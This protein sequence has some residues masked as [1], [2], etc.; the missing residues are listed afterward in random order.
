MIILQGAKLGI[1]HNTKRHL[2][3]QDASVNTNHLQ[4][5]ENQLQHMRRQQQDQ[6]ASVYLHHLQGVKNYLLQEMRRE[7]E[8]ATH[9]SLLLERGGPVDGR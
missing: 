5:A 7:R 9:R 8:D 1:M 2:L 6:D 3:Y 4:G